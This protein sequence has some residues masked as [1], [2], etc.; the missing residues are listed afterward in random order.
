MASDE[1]R[2][3]ITQALASALPKCGECS[4]WMKS[5]ECPKEHNVKGMSRGPSCDAL[6]CDK[7]L[8]K[9]TATAERVAER[10]KPFDEYVRGQVTAETVTV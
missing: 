8:T 7:F 10:R 4:H 9:D 6:A 5:R 2:Y 3:A 1:I